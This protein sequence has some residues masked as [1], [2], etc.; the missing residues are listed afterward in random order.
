[1]VAR[2]DGLA[3]ARRAAGFTQEA[4][5]E[6]LQV[7]PSTIRNWESGKTEPSPY[8]RPKLARLLGIAAAQ[9]DALLHDPAAAGG[10]ALGI[11]RTDTTTVSD[12]RGCFEQ[13]QR[14]YDTAPTT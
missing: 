12:L 10:G 2:R 7:D 1:M 3:R 4:L 13:V 9:L 6:A 8:K 11:G 14:H 5:A